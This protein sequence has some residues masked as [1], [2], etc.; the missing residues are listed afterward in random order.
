MPATHPSW[1][2]LACA[3]IP[4]GVRSVGI[5]VAP[6]AD[7]VASPS[8]DIP[9]CVGTNSSRRNTAARCPTGPYGRSP[10]T[11]APR[12]GSSRTRVASS[13]ST[14]AR[15]TRATRHSVRS[16]ESSSILHERTATGLPAERTATG[17]L[18]R[19]PPDDRLTEPT[20]QLHRRPATR[21]ANLGDRPRVHLGARPTANSTDSASLGA[22]AMMPQQY[23]P[24]V[25]AG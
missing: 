2:A 13:R 6:S 23:L 16:S 12:P 7:T 15:S 22:E 20:H 5:M 25:L 11:A 21:P 17:H 24:L 3:A 18:A 8:T 9:E 10:E 14:A 19:W 1:S 4:S